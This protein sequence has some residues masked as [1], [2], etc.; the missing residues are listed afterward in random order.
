MKTGK[1]K[2]IELMVVW[3][4]NSQFLETDLTLGGNREGGKI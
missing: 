1:E 4:A 3:E 2:G